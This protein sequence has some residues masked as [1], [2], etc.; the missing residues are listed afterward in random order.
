[1]NRPLVVAHRGASAYRA[2]HTLAAYR[3]AL[4]QGADGLECDVRVTRDGQLVCV[5]DRR[6]DR[7][8]SGR[9]VVS[10]TDY[11]DLAGHDYG[12]W[13]D[14]WESAD[15]LVAARVLA[16]ASDPADRGLLTLTALLELVA[17]WNRPV[18]LF[19]E[20][21]HPVR[22]GGL[23][24]AKLVA[25]LVRFGMANPPTR[26][27]SDVYLMSFS[28]TALRRFRADAPQLPT[29]LLTGAL[30]PR[31]DGKIPR[32]ADLTGPGIRTLRGDPDYVA[33]AA[34]RGHPTYVWTVDEAADL[35][36]CVEW[37]VHSI[38]T[39]RPSELV[40]LMRGR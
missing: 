40:A 23:V 3:L 18:R 13:H 27:D 15:E 4:E 35:R 7:T 17:D 24:E 6:I 34:R 31:A 21:K 28:V 12:G 9:G 14:E 5:H 38:G 32:C 22:Y 2:E 39:N 33:R 26:A 1:M 29:V 25:L 8:S 16:E 30:T 10:A 20:T 37:G 11:A 19:L 36:N